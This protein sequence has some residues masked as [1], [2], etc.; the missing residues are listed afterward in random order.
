[1]VHIDLQDTKVKEP[2][3]YLGDNH[4]ILGQDPNTPRV[5]E[6]FLVLNLAECLLLPVMLTLLQR[7]LSLNGTLL[8]MCEKLRYVLLK[9][10]C[11]ARG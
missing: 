6:R 4:R 9:H 3:L 10:A 8:K 2:L 1:M 7:M 11:S 5:R